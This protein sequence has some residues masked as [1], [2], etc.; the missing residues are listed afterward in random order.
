[1]RG[2]GGVACSGQGGSGA[3]QFAT[4]TGAEFCLARF[5]PYVTCKLCA[6]GALLAGRHRQPGMVSQ[7]ARV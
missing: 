1:M 4:F 7:V 3:I 2:V 5:G 6:F